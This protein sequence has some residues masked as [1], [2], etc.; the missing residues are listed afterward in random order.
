MGVI[1]HLADILAIYLMMHLLYADHRKARVTDIAVAAGA[2]LLSCLNIHTGEFQHIGHLV[3]TAAAVTLLTEIALRALVRAALLYLTLSAVQVYLLSLAELWGLPQKAFIWNIAGCVLLCI[4]LLLMSKAVSL[5]AGDKL[6]L[7]SLAAAIFMQGLII[8]MINIAVSE[9]R[10]NLNSLDK[11]I[12]TISFPTVM[13]VI[14]LLLHQHSVKRIEQERRTFLEKLIETERSHFLEQEQAM[15]S[16][17]KFRHDQ[18]NLSA[19]MA[20][21]IRDKKYAE[22][23]EFSA[24]LNERINELPYSVYSGNNIADAVI[25]EK[26][27]QA[28]NH[29]IGF[30]FDGMIPERSAVSDVELAS[31]LS[32]LLDNAIRSAESIPNGYVKTVCRCDKKH[33]MITVKNSCEKNLD[34]KRLNTSKD[35]SSEHG[36]GLEIVSSIVR[37]HNGELRLSAVD[38]EFTAEVLVDV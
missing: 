21:L 14:L 16:L 1:S 18:N 23:E 36:F 31:I 27:E 15:L 22:L 11:L 10:A 25:N 8:A 6:T 37:A 7:I 32:N 5:R 9:N 26:L 2:M 29:G 20:Q 13:A 34:T 30:D 17:R 24:G 38:R 28:K 33:L 3:I 35:F 19:V 12:F 4:L